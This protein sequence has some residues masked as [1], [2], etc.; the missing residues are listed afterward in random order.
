MANCNK[1]CE[2]DDCELLEI[3]YPITFYEMNG[4]QET[5]IT[6][7]GVKC[8]LNAFCAET[9]KDLKYGKVYTDNVIFLGY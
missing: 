2:C 9:K 4:F 1:S 7:V 5:K 6:L 3:N 8:R